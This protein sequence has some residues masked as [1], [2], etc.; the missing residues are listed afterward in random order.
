MEMENNTD[1]TEQ[2][3]FIQFNGQIDNQN[4]RAFRVRSN[5]LESIKRAIEHHNNQIKQLEEAIRHHQQMKKKWTSMETAANQYNK[6][7]LEK[8]LAAEQEC[9]DTFE[10][11]NFGMDC[12]WATSK[13]AKNSGEMKTVLS[14]IILLNRQGV[15]ISSPVSKRKDLP[16]TEHSNS[17][18]VA[19]LPVIQYPPPTNLD[20]DLNRKPDKKEDQESKEATK[21]VPGQAE[22]L[23]ETGVRFAK[24][25]NA[26]KAPYT[27]NQNLLQR[28]REDPE[29]AERKS[30][31]SDEQ[32]SEESDEEKECSAEKSCQTA[33]SEES[34]LERANS[35]L[36]SCDLEMVAESASET[37]LSRQSGTSSRSNGGQKKKGKKGKKAQKGPK[38]TLEEIEAIKKKKREEKDKEYAKKQ[39]E[40]QNHL[41]KVQKSDRH[42]IHRRLAETALEILRQG[43]GIL[44]K[45]IQ[46]LNDHLDD[47]VMK[48]SRT[49]MFK[50]RNDYLE[51]RVVEISRTLLGS[52]LAAKMELMR[53]Y[54]DIIMRTATLQDYLIYLATLDPRGEEYRNFE[55][56]TISLYMNGY[57]DEDELENLNIKDNFQAFKDAGRT[58]IPDEQKWHTSNEFTLSRVMAF[59]RMAQISEL[60]NDD[61]FLKETYLA[62]GQLLEVFNQCTNFDGSM[63]P[64]IKETG[65]T[66]FGKHILN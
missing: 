5:N 65:S 47:F 17:L 23:P 62:M 64:G 54:H 39:E 13:K 66:R 26:D 50:L 27:R 35:S 18:S 29:V 56:R 19:S 59:R 2:V 34:K 16:A 31:F 12:S 42:R 15:E 63:V 61:N 21:D 52:E 38:M 48:T 40:M 36:G 32:E 14:S 60:S 10:N 6:I 49:E 55:L 24:L 33:G 9:I 43:S 7:Y 46:V 58:Q 25:S 22:Q 41:D 30:L 45:E 44:P 3:F 57:E 37:S 53:M 28:P 8:I 11:E 4:Y 20:P 1:T 51:T